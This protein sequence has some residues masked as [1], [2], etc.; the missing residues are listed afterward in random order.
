MAYKENSLNPD[1]IKSEYGLTREPIQWAQTF[2][3]FLAQYDRDNRKKELS[4]AQIRRFFGL[5]KRLQAK[6]YTQQSRTDLLMLTPQLAYA[7]GRDKKKTRRGLIDSSKIHY[8]YREISTA[9][10]AVAAETIEKEQIHFKNFVNLVEA[11]VAYH[12][13]A[14]GE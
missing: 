7:V 11:I 10:E 3:E 12:R 6:G 9:V 14:G 4:T 1:W 8:F 2:G 13:F 5:I